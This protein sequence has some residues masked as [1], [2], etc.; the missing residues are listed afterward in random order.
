MSTALTTTS[1]T[2]IASIMNKKEASEDEIKAVIE[3]QKEAIRQSLPAYMTAE[4]FIRII[5]NCCAKNPELFKCTPQ[6]IVGA[7]MTLA[8]LGLDPDLGLAHLVPFNSKVN[9]TWMKLCQLIIDYKGFLQLIMNT[10]MVKDAYAEIIY[11]NDV[12]NEVLG[13][14]RTLTHLKPPIGQ[15]RGEPIA[16]YAVVS[17]LNGGRLYHLMTRQEV[18]EHAKKYS[19]QKDDNGNLKN[20]WKNEFD[21]MALKTVIRQVAKY[22]PKSTNLLRSI[23]RDGTVT[24][25]LSTDMSYSNKQIELQRQ[26]FSDTYSPAPAALTMND[27]I[28]DDTPATL[29]DAIEAQQVQQEEFIIENQVKNFIMKQQ[30]LM[31]SDTAVKKMLQE[32]GFSPSGSRKEIYKSKF[33]EAKKAL[34]ELAKEVNKTDQQQTINVGNADYLN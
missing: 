20:I 10:G 19:K 33:L 23:D 14:E 6:S 5:L 2:N 13:T 12:F 27:Y 9:G 1:K 8:Q 29:D 26:S 32:K 17:L 3:S 22:A 18:E 31:V 24:E 34:E 11:S 28:G 25:R 15:D 30:E 4:K 16:Y 7:V 21:K